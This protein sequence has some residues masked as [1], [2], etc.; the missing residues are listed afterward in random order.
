MSDNTHLYIRHALTSATSMTSAKI[1][2]LAQPSN[3]LFPEMELLGGT[4]SIRQRVGHP[5]PS[6]LA[7]I[8]LS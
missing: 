5:L 6:A 2:R 1:R 7:L 3:L 4:N 8:V